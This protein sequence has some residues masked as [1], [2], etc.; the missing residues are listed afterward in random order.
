MERWFLFYE[1]SYWIQLSIVIIF[2]ME[3]FLRFLVAPKRSKFFQQK[4]N[5][6]DNLVL[7]PFWLNRVFR[8]N[9]V[10]E[11]LSVLSVF[12]CFLWYLKFT[13]YYTDAYLLQR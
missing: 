2:T 12:S 11:Y 13:R 4:Q 1:C 8:L 3:A 5:I 10:F 9:L 6:I 7:I